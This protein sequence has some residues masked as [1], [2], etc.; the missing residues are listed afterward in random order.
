VTDLTGNAGKG[1]P[2]ISGWGRRSLEIPGI[3]ASCW[4]WVPGMETD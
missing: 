2:A 1:V 4:W 3:P